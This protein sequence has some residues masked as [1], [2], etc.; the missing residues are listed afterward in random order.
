[1]SVASIHQSVTYTCPK[2]GGGLMD[3]LRP[4][5]DEKHKCWQGHWVLGSSEFF[6]DFPPLSPPILIQI[7]LDGME[8]HLMN[9][10]SC[11]S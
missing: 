2:P 11:I 5:T 10:P 8:L 1:M 4:Q 9:L 3:C 6:I 7:S